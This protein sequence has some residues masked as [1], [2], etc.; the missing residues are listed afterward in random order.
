MMC[1]GKTRRTLQRNNDVR[2]CCTAFAITSR[3][4]TGIAEVPEKCLLRGIKRGV[5]R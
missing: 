3:L 2:K 5:V 1:F 4:L